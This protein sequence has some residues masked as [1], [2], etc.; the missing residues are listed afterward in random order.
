MALKDWKRIRNNK[1]TIVYERKKAK[2]GFGGIIAINKRKL[3]KGVSP[4]LYPNFKP[5]EVVYQ[6]EVG[7]FDSGVGTRD[8]K[9]KSQAL[10]FAKSI[11]RKY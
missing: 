6:Y 9:T 2:R 4:R 5:Y 10:K 7:G 8:F 11:M 1:T 3:P